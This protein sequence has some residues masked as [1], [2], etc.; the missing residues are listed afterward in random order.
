M[1]RVVEVNETAAGAAIRRADPP[2]VVAVGMRNQASAV[3]AALASIWAQ[4]GVVG[5]L[6]VLLFDDE[7]SDSWRP[8]VRD[9]AEP[10]RLLVVRGRAGSAA[11]ARN[12]LLD[13]ARRHAPRLELIVRLDA[14]DRLYDDS[15]LA[16]VEAKFK[17]VT[18][19][20]GHR[21]SAL[22]ASNLQSRDHVVLPWPNLAT[23]DL[24]DKSRL[25]ER[26]AG[27]AS[28]EPHAELPSCNLVLR[29]DVPARYPA[30][31]SAE[32]H[33]L[34]AAL[35]LGSHRRAV[36]VDDDLMLTVYSL[37]GAASSGNHRKRAYLPAR[38]ALLAWARTR[39]AEIRR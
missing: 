27:M 37:S 6:L 16:R 23:S 10:D 32:D 13:L 26:I 33:W 22:L 3:G 1:A 36:M 29:P 17:R 4:R 5:R 9:T 11:A 39:H 24:L 25:L 34:T 28:G 20:R 18:V 35:L 15:A 7:S 31:R 14:D 38:R 21:A 2:I 12:L 19:S 30:C 8:R